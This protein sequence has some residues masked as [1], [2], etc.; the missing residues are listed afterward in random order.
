MA[1]AELMSAADAVWL[2]MDDPTNLMF[3]AGVFVFDHPLDID[4]LKATLE[5]RLLRFKRFRQ[6][7]VAGPGLANPRWED[8][9]H[10][11]IH[12]HVHRMGLPQP[13]DQATLQ[14]MISTL[15]SSPLDRSKPLW[16]MHVLENYQGEGCA[17]FVRI[18]HAIA[19]G[20]A[21]I[22]V[23]MSLMDEGPNAPWP[24]ANAETARRQRGWN[25]LDI[26]L[27]PAAT[28]WQTTQ[29]LT[30]Q[31]VNQGYDMLMQPTKALALAQSA[32][33]LVAT[34]GRMLSLG[35]DT[36]TAIRGPLGIPK[37]VA[38]SEPLPLAEVK[39]VGRVIGATVNDVLLSLLTAA[40]R[41]YLAGRGEPVDEIEI[42]LMVP[43]TLRPLEKA[44]NLGNNFGTVTL[45]LPINEADPLQRLRTLKERMDALKESPEALITFAAM[46]TVGYTPAQLA[47]KIIE[48]FNRSCSAIMT[49]VPGPRQP[50]Y[51]AGQKVQSIMIWG[52]LGGRIGLGA[53][54]FSYNGA[55]TLGIFADAGLT[56]DPETIVDGFV[57]A[58]AE[59]KRLVIGR[60]QPTA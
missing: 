3:V 9:P 51:I 33:R 2:H 39:Q 12:A 19:D 53:S 55:V 24:T 14:K 32:G 56:P 58:F 13:G 7:V 6:R 38:W 47:S 21:L 35:T 37:Q 52:P 40:L 34:V 30:T 31:A 8:D 25:P 44:A 49:N 16:Q 41:D 20:I 36:P 23:L 29:R 1:R 26:L 48:I 50:V 43:V 46:A 4:R 57:V 18:H 10:F 27:G 45:V 28:A 42:R 15:T 54:I 59:L 60:E 11:D 22:Y 5:V 17:L